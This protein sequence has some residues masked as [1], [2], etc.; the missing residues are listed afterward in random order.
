ML[1][2]VSFLPVDELYL[3]GQLE[4]L[5]SCLCLFHPDEQVRIAEYYPNIAENLKKLPKAEEKIAEAKKDIP[6]GWDVAANG[7]ESFGIALEAYLK[8]LSRQG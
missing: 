4:F 7:N 1:V 2:L 5:S 3:D 6:K 8:E